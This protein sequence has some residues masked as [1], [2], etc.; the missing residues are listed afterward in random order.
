M[1]VPV[2]VRVPGIPFE[3]LQAGEEFFQHAHR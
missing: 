1:V 3:S 2:L